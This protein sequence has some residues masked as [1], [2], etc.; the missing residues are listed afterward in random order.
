MNASLYVCLFL[1]WP[2][3]WFAVLSKF[4]DP[5]VLLGSVFGGSLEGIL[6]LFGPLLALV[7]FSRKAWLLLPQQPRSP[8]P[9]A[10]FL[11]FVPIFNVFWQYRMLYRLGAVVTAEAANLD[12]KPEVADA[13]PK[14][15]CHLGWIAWLLLCA[16]AFGNPVP[17]LDFLVIAGG[18]LGGLWLLC[19][20]IMLSHFSNVISRIAGERASGDPGVGR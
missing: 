20:I 17:R 3:G 5:A 2:A 19:A 7:L 10:A 1:G 8:K 18:I 9:N 12:P 16:S 6:V 11:L 14:A 13:I 4:T 15:F